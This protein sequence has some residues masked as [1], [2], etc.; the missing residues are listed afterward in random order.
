METIK[1]SFNQKPSFNRTQR[2]T[3]DP[4]GVSG[5]PGLLT[6]DTMQNK[7]D[8][9]PGVGRE[10]DICNAS[11]SEVALLCKAI[12]MWARSTTMALIE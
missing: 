8:L 11:H 4:V 2:T 3:I 7:A 6:N 1:Q 9:S 10:A 5:A 12:E